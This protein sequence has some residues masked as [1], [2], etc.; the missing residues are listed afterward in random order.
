MQGHAWMSIEDLSYDATG[1]CLSD[2][3][4]TYK[5]PDVH[6]VPR[7]LEIRLLEGD[8]AGPGPFGSKAVGEPPLMYGIGFFFAL[9]DAMRAFRSDL[10]VDFQA[11]LTPERVLTQLHSDEMLRLGR[12][13]P[14]QAVASES[15]DGRILARTE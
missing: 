15:V 10:E 8:T 9:R 3:L 13:F 14:P 6:R 7:E 11:P 4:S 1:H 5:I 12:Q 2:T